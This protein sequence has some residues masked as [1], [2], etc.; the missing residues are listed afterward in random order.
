MTTFGKHVL[1]SSWVLQPQ[2]GTGETAVTKT[3]PH[4]TLP[5]EE[6]DRSPVTHDQG[7]DGGCS[8]S[9][10]GNEGVPDPA[11][12]IREGFLESEKTES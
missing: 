5:M 8:C 4:P 12:E 6:T 7:R 9:S 2:L 3:D 10:E 1:G 11:W